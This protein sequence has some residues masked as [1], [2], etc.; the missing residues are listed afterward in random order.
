MGLPLP[1]PREAALALLKFCW[2]QIKGDA[3]T[4]SPI[5]LPEDD[6]DHVDLKPHVEI[7]EPHIGPL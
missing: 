1:L 6:V 3:E 5:A 4:G 2:R 7:W